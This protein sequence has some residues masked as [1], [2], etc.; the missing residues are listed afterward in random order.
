M[1]MVALAFNIRNGWQISVKFKAGLVYTA[2]SRTA[3]TTLV[4][5]CQRERDRERET[6]RDR[7]TDRERLR[8]RQRGMPLIPALRRQ[9]LADLCEVKDSLVYIV[10]SRIA[11]VT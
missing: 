9:R 1:D 5:P 2:S 6:E 4:R 8:E 10:S 7:D 11:R 3:M